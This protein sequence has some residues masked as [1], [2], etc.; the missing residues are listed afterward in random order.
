MQVQFTVIFFLHFPLDQVLYID[1][2]RR[3]ID[4]TMHKNLISFFLDTMYVI[5]GSLHNVVV[6]QCH[7]DKYLSHVV[8]LFKIFIRQF[9]LFEVM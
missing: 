8:P 9:E 7:I 3:A 4:R 2:I 6:V 5:T 1:C